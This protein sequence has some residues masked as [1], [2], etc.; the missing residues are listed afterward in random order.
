M[1]SRRLVFVLLVA[2]SATAF[3]KAAVPESKWASLDDNKIHYYDTGKTKAK[4]ALVLI[5]GWACSADFW[6]DS[7]NAFPSYRVITVDLPG[8]RPERQTKARLFDR[9]FRES[10][11]RGFETGRRKEC[12]AR[13]P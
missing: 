12:R 2:T 6:R 9:A 4:D 13:G 3:A 8:A 1:R 7:Y 10:G 11:R 5:H